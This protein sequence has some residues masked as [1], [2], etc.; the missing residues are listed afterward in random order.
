MYYTS[1]AQRSTLQTGCHDKIIVR[2]KMKKF[3]T[4]T[5][6]SKPIETYTDIPDYML[7]HDIQ[8]TTQNGEHLQVLI[9]CIINGWPL[10]EAEIR[11]DVQL[12][13]TFCD[14]LVV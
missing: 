3:P 12:Y 7:T 14:N 4:R 6:A 10:T 8:G 11:Q 9:A 13:W 1:L 5:L 2:T